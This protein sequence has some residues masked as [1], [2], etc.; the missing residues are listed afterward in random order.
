M[1]VFLRQR[2]GLLGFFGAASPDFSSVRR[3]LASG[4]KGLPGWACRGGRSLCARWH[5]FA[6]CCYHIRKTGGVGSGIA[7]R[8]NHYDHAFRASATVEEIGGNRGCGR[9]CMLFGAPALLADPSPNSKLGFAVIG[10]GGRSA[11]HLP[12]AAAERL[13]ALAD[14]DESRMDLAVQGLG[15]VARSG[16]LPAC[17][18]VG[19]GQTGSLPYESVWPSIP[20]SGNMP[21]KADRLDLRARSTRWVPH[22]LKSGL[23]PSKKS[24][25]G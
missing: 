25:P 12:A 18:G 7:L 19:F 9:G 17:R 1:R 8:R 15:V 24:W 5:S 11:A 2:P 4:T 23:W 3:R 10:C 13:I 16:K 21:K 22:V 6:P 14:P 20:G